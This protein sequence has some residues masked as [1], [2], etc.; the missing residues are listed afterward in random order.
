MNK[1]VVAKTL[2]QHRQAKRMPGITGFAGGTPIEAAS[3]DASRM[4]QDPVL[5]PDGERSAG[6]R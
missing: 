4:H 5:Q 6:H 1:D 2:R 3:C